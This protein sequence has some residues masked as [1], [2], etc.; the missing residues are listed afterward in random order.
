MRPLL[1]DTNDTVAEK[2]TLEKATKRKPE[3]KTSQQ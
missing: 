3:T 2:V 1:K